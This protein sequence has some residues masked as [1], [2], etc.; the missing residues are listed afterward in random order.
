MLIELWFHHLALNQ[1]PHQHSTPNIWRGKQS[2][3]DFFIPALLSQESMWDLTIYPLGSRA[4]SWAHR[5]VTRSN[6]ICNSPNSLLV[7]TVRFGSLHFIQFLKSLLG[8]GFHTLI[9]NSPSS[10]KLMCDLT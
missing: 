1:K 10:L 7:D 5:P 3:N 8:R 4:S 2:T 9:K 6:T